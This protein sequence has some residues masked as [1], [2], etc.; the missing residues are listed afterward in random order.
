MIE[1][2]EWVKPGVSFAWLN[3]KWHVRGLVDG[4]AVCR[5]WTPSKQRWHYEWIHPVAF[6]APTNIKR[7]ARGVGDG[8]K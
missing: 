6:M 3:K 1:L 7:H 8:Q 5:H 2:P 4:G